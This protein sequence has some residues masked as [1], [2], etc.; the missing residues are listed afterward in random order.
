L[1]KAAWLITTP[2]I[3][4]AEKQK[5]YIFHKESGI[6]INFETDGPPQWGK[7][8]TAQEKELLEFEGEIKEAIEDINEDHD[9]NVVP[10]PE[11]EPVDV[12]FSIDF[13]LRIDKIET[14]EDVIS[15]AFDPTIKMLAAVC[16]DASSETGLRLVLA[17]LDNI[18]FVDAAYAPD[19]YEEVMALMVKPNGFFCEA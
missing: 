2:P 3:F 12:T 15:Y 19:K 4:M 8:V 14:V 10:E 7:D 5:C 1:S 16:K 18:V 11:P 17:N 13:Q 6:K 9:K